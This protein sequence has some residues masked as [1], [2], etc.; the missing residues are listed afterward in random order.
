VKNEN[1]IAWRDERPVVMAPDLICLVDKS[2]NGVTNSGLQKGL[3]VT[4]LGIRS[5]PIWRTAK[6][7]EHFGTERFGFSFQYVPLEQIHGRRRDNDI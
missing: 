6:G 5:A 3:E 2:G 7:L 1:I 4:V